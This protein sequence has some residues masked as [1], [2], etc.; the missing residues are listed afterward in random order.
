MRIFR[1]KVTVI[2]VGS[3]ICANEEKITGLNQEDQL[4]NL[5]RI[6]LSS[7]V[8]CRRLGIDSLYPSLMFCWSV[9]TTSPLNEGPNLPSTP[10]FER[11]VS[12][13]LTCCSQSFVWVVGDEL[14]I[15]L[16]CSGEWVVTCWVS[17]EIYLRNMT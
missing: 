10:I 9:S 8:I 13:K 14:T 3:Q 5:E 1:S 17:R 6:G 7:E 16:D 15:S 2:H 11:C 4:D 12:T